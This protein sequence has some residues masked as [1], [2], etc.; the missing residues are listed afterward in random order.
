M[1]S[2]RPQHS[3]FGFFVV[4]RHRKI[5]LI[6]KKEHR[7]KLAPSAFAASMPLSSARQSAMRPIEGGVHLEINRSS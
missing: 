6:S 7:E 5:H 3:L 4:D 2:R 1:V